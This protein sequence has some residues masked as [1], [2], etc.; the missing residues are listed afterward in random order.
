MKRFINLIAIVTTLFL[1]FGCGN[2]NK[3]MFTRINK[4]G[5]IYRE[6][7]QSGDSSFLMGDTAKSNPFPIRLDSSW[8]VTFSYTKKGEPENYISGW[9]VKNYNLKL[10]TSHF[11]S[12]KAS[13]T[14]QNI[15]ELSGKFSF[16]K[17]PW[18]SSLKQ[19]FTLHKKF[20]WFYT[21]YDYTETFKKLNPNPKTKISDFLSDSEIMHYFGE[22]NSYT[23]GCN[24]VEALSYLKVLEEKTEKWQFKCIYD[25]YFQVM[26]D[27][28]DLLPEPKVTLK[29]FQSVQDSI[30]YDHLKDIDILKEKSDSFLFG[31]FDKYFATKNFSK[32]FMNNDSLKKVFEKSAEKTL[33]DY[34]GRLSYN[35]SMPGK[36]LDTNA[37]ISHGDTLTWNVNSE[38]FLFMDYS[39]YAKSRNPNYWAFVISGIIVFLGLLGLIIKRK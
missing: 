10:D 27:N 38:R 17:I 7:V 11:L 21:Y 9:P 36:I 22:D 18:C 19:E 12:V 37:S 4:D 32:I 23:K 20:R 24:G 8:K 33:V 34:S 16:N 6:F 2:D 30:F 13:K 15:E 3:Y 35:L 28:Y 29:R 14:F 1:L 26:C 25:A 5:S 39:I 31:T